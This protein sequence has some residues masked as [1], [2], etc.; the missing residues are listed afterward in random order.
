MFLL[1]SKNLAASAKNVKFFLQ[2]KSHGPVGHGTLARLMG[3]ARSGENHCIRPVRR[4]HA[5][6]SNRFDPRPR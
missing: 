5:D 1:L 2:A 3:V 4:T 6:D